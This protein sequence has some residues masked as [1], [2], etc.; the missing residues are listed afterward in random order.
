MEAKTSARSA[1]PHGPKAKAD[2]GENQRHRG[3]TPR[4]AAAADDRDGVLA[5]DVDLPLFAI[6]R[7]RVARRE[8]IV[9]RSAWVGRI[10]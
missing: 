6:A 1:T 5:W 9:V 4:R 7:A 3:I 2:N 10:A 8:W